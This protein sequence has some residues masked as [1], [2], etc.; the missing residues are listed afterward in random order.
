[1]FPGLG[2]G[3]VDRNGGR[4]AYT[5]LGEDARSGGWEYACRGTG[6][7]DMVR[8]GSFEPRVNGKGKYWGS[9]NKAGFFQTV[10][11]KLE[12]QKDNFRIQK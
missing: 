6:E 2:V 9:P 3:K 12:H 5:R 10:N 8:K 4:I 11:I 7:D 1:V